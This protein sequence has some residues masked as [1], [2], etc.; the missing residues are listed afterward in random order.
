MKS[1]LIKYFCTK[2]IDKKLLKDVERHDR[3][4]CK[5][6]HE[7]RKISGIANN[8]NRIVTNLTGDTL[9]P[10]EERVLSFGLKHGL[11]TRLNESDV[12]ASAESIWDQ[13][14]RKNLLP[15]G[16]M[17]QQKIKN[18]IK[19]LAC[20]FLDFEDRKM[21]EDSRHIKILK[22]LREKYAILRP[23]KGN[24]VVLIKKIEYIDWL[25][26]I[27][28][29]A[30]KFRK[31]EHDPTFTQLNSPERYL[32]TINKRNEIDDSTYEHIRPQSTR[33]AR[34]HGLPKTH[35]SFDVLP[36]FRPIIDTTGTAYQ[37]LA[38]YLSAL[39][40]PLA[41]NE[42][43]LKDSF[44]A[45]TRIHNIPPQL[46]V[47]GYRYVSFDVKSLFTNI[48]LKKVIKIIL[49]RVYDDKQISSNLKPRTLKKLLKDCCTKTPFSF[50]G[51]LYHQIDGVSIGSPLGPTLANI[52][53]T[54]LED[55]IIRPL[56][57]SDKLKFYVRYVNDTLILAKPE[58]IPLILE[59]LNSFRPQIQFTYE[60]FVDHNDVHFLDIKF[61]SQGTTIY[62]KST[63]T[64][65]YRHYS[66]FTPW[67][68]KVAW[69]RALVHRATK[70]CSTQQLLQLEILNIKRFASWNGFPRWICDKLINTYS[71][72]QSSK[73]TPGG[74]EPEPTISI[75]WIRLPFIGQK[76]N[77]LLRNCTRKISRLLKQ[78]VKFMN[79]WET[80]DCKLFHFSK[81]SYAKPYKS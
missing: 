13:L 28:S 64:G 43:S 12:V 41:Q 27:F 57:T 22:T 3:K 77:F 52:L 59:K 20:N 39:L 26:A 71:T 70:I 63:H 30:T 46:V 68:R 8:P 37:P 36:P 23:D 58:D 50:N 33:P 80:T 61:D 54:E 15:D 81:R 10:E 49:K 19:A 42:F 18:S 4:F 2:P 1:I 69:I 67:S 29:D 65:Q 40:S 32:R 7:S 53:M 24:G 9:T 47:Q 72:S 45:V 75:I 6:E 44:D 74:K 17:K 16:Y 25:S 78:P 55:D 62:R 11:A 48:P 21:S 35:K 79:Q 14:Q 73:T 31:L 5:L 66:S 34:A 76:G 56:I 60:E 51:A 38:K